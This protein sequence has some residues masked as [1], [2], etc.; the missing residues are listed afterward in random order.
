MRFSADGPSIPDELLEQ[1]DQGNVVFLCGAGVS[2]PAGLPSFLTL[3][4]RVMKALGTPCHAKS[5]QLLQG[6]GKS[7][8]YAPPLDQVFN[9]LQQEYRREQ[10]EDAVN[11]ILKTPRNANVETHSI[12]LRLS[13]NAAR[14]PQVVTTNFDLLFERADPSLNVHISP[15]L[16]DLASVDCFDGVVYLHGRRSQTPAIGVA[17]QGLVLSSSDFGRAYLADGWATRFVRDLLHS[18]V[19]VLVGYS[20]S[21]PPVRYLLEGLHSR[22]GDKSGNIFAFDHGSDDEVRDR[23]RSLGVRALAYTLTPE[24]SHS[25]LWN[26]LKAWAVRAD[27]PDA[28][29]RL[30]VDQARTN[31]R[32]L[33]A[34]QRG[35]VASLVRTTEGAA[36]FAY[37]TPPPPAEWLCVF[38]RFVRYSELKAVLRS[39]QCDPLSAY[40]LDDDPPRPNEELPEGTRSDALGDDLISLGSRDERMDRHKRLAGTLRRASDPLPARL[41]HLARWFARVLADPAA[42]WWAAGYTVMH[43]E[44]LAAIEQHLEQ[45]QDDVGVFGSRVWRLLLERFRRSPEGLH[46]NA[47]YRFAPRLKREGWTPLVLLRFERVVQPYL[48]AK[49]PFGNRFFPPMPAEE[50]PRL[51]DVVDLEVEFPIAGREDVDIPTAPLPAVFDVV[52]R[53]LERG[54]NLLAEI[55]TRYWHTASFDPPEQ[56]GDRYLNDASR[57]LHWVRALFDRMVLEHPDVARNELRRW[58][59]D[60]QYFFNK[61]KIYAWMNRNLVAGHEAASGIV[62]LSESG[63]W[64]EYHR[65]ELLHTLG[66]RWRDF[67][68]E[69]RQEI[70]NRILAGRRQWD[71]E[72][73]EDYRLSTNRTAATML[74]WLEHHGCELSGGTRK[75]LRTLRASVPG[76]TPSWDDAAD[77]SLDG[78]VGFVATDPDPS[79][80]ISAPVSVVLALAE[81][82]TAKETDL[83]FTRHAPFDG[84]VAQHPRRALAALSIE[85][86]QAKYPRQFWRTLLAH[87]PKHTSDR[88]LRVCAGRLSRL[89]DAVVVECRYDVTRWFSESASRLARISPDCAFNLA[90]RIVDSLFGA[91]AEASRSAI[92]DVTLAGKTLV[93]SRRTYDHAINSPIGHVAKALFTILDGFRLA[94]GAG[95]PREI[96]CR[97]E[98]LLQLP[99]EGADHAVCETALRL[100]W[101][102][103]IDSSWTRARIVPLLDPGHAFAEPAWNGFLQDSQL[104]GPEL[105]ALLKPHFLRAFESASAWHWDSDTAFNRL[106]ERLVVA[107]YWKQ[108]DR[109]YVSYSEARTAL[110]LVDDAGRAHAV[111]FL[112][113]AFADEGWWGSF[114]RPFIQKA[115]PRESRFQTSSV[116]QQLAFLA[117]QSGDQFPDVVNTVLPLLAPVDQLDMTIYRATRADSAPS[118]ADRFPETMLQLL[119]RL[120]S[121]E[122][123][124]VPYGLG[125]I[126]EAI[127]VS[128]PNLRQDQRWKRLHSIAERG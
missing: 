68:A 86:R 104:A 64:E 51:G 29:R 61:L 12:I 32:Q 73:N 31:P 16:P 83:G 87:W 111:W 30:I 88:L 58:P 2:R 45:S 25:A 17:R 70:E 116:S 93:R 102:F 3:A 84:L 6:A 99:G 18:Y 96:R 40:G 19:I 112:A 52:R 41:S 7:T 38:D 10:V 114:G 59:A 109:R 24:S 80:I 78:R 53:A 82:H 13:R 124:Y 54:A 105:F 106:V 90:D 74:G 5:H 127:V 36:L 115:W 55:E 60:D 63:F 92:G 39:E 62:S 76:W 48:V 26:T 1:R 101:L 43:D 100:R 113:T 4:R 108:R 79:Q 34:Y 42:A 89:P 28:W 119:D 66:S 14:R 11:R 72:E 22:R 71:G 57:Y 123:R 125:P 95:I 8:D 107:C 94:A 23:W 50:T 21:D 110:R 27:D 65:R 75:L 128:S 126:L 121:D 122:P 47:W 9:L 33:E 85:A 98:R 67:S 20:A 118:L 91:G 49:R 103:S 77:H 97:L 120:I 69:V 46:D 15:L 35:Q 37:A 81:R 117:E 44:L 56:A